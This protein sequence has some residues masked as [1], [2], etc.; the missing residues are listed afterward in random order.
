[1]S[2]SNS[3]EAHLALYD[4]LTAAPRARKHGWTRLRV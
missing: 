3:A 1:M 4:E 2:L